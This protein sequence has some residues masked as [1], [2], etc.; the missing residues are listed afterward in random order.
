MFMELK[1]ASL[2][3]LGVESVDA[4][5]SIE[6]LVIPLMRVKDSGNFHMIS[7]E[8]LVKILDFP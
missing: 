2:K 5:Q 4:T 6:R 8:A 3:R 1:L 7:S